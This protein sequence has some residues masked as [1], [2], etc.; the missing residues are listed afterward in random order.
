M[1]TNMHSSASG[2]QILHRVGQC[3]YRSAQSGRY[4]AIVKCAGRQI[5]K[6]LKT[7]DRALAKRR[8]VELKGKVSRL[9]GDA[10]SRERFA[11]VAQ[12]W[13]D[14][15]G[16]TM[17]AASLGRMESIVKNLNT[18]FGTSRTRAILRTDLERWAARRI[19]DVSARTFN[20]DRQILIRIFEFA[21]QGG[22]VLENPA[23][24]LRHMKEPKHKLV[25]PGKDQFQRLVRAMHECGDAGVAGANLC[26]LLAYS[27]CRLTEG[28]EMVWGDVDFEKKSFTVTGGELGTKNHEARVVPL[29]PAFE[30]FLRSLLASREEPPDPAEKI[31]PVASAKILMTAACKSARLPHFTHHHLRHFFCSNA[32]EVG[33]DF[34]TIAGWLGH[35][36]GGIL[37]A[38][39]YGH[40]RDE[41]S[42][43]MAQKMSFMA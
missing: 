16:P 31:S 25:I 23:A 20:Y 10:G 27:G 17:K 6:S 12:R 4:Y 26:E 39:T 36:D 38:R 11:E 30:Q 18:T 14:A 37:V 22:I 28:A 1:K 40:L 33:I 41:H 13:L 32:I 42:A 29:F 34:K 43:A 15:D 19:K 24:A 7:C 9:S 35:K 21:M 5:K 3:L 8:L 2:N